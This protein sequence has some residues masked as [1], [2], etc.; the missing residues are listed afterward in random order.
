MS[1]GVHPFQNHLVVTDGRYGDY[2]EVKK[3][4]QFITVDGNDYLLNEKKMNAD[5][6]SSFQSF[7]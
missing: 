6:F 4:D 3:N 1:N 5:Q 2:F 7:M